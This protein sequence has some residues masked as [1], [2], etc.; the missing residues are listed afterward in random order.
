MPISYILKVLF[1]WQPIQRHQYAN[2]LL[3]NGI[4]R[5]FMWLVVRPVVVICSCNDQPCVSTTIARP[6]VDSC[7]NTTVGH[8]RRVTAVTR[9][10]WPTVNTSRPFMNDISYYWPYTV[11]TNRTISRTTN[12]NHLKSIRRLRPHYQVVENNGRLFPRQRN[13]QHSCD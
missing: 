1:D 5:H 6:V 13:R 10:R 4:S 12:H 9:I 7:D 2:T 8:R 3:V 11:V